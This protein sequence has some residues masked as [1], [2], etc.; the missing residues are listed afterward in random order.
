MVMPPGLRS[1]RRRAKR[2]MQDHL[3]ITRTIKRW[4]DETKK[5][6]DVKQVVYDNR[7]SIQTYEPH[8]TGVTAGEH[9]Y[10]V[11]R[12]QAKVPID[13]PQIRIG[14]E[15]HVVEAVYDDNLTG[16]KY[17]VQGLLHKSYATSQR[18]LVDETVK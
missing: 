14:D 16:R 6:T 7:G 2:R 1:G 3:R 5:N 4:D 15:V 17:T 8:E 11:Q 9:R 18:L 12:Y 10:A 13:A